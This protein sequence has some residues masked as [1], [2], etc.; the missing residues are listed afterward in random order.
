MK[1]VGIK[2]TFIV[3]FVLSIVS[4]GLSG[5]GLYRAL[6]AGHGGGD[7]DIVAEHLESATD[8]DTGANKS[9]GH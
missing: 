1:F 3:A 7:S 6:S 9:K 4:L 8:S 2:R 5:I